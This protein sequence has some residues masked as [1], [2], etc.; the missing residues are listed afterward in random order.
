MSAYAAIV[1]RDARVAMRR[2]GE[3]AN[4]LLFFLIVTTLFPLALS[5][6][7]DELREVGVGV[8]WVSTLLSSL[9]ALE[10]LF[11]SDADDGSL[12]QLLL[13]PV[14][15][16]VTVLAKI[17]A[18]WLI[19]ILP[20]IALVPVLALSYSMPLSALPIMLA[21]LVLAT[22][23]LSVLIAIGAALTVSLRRG[24]TIVGLLV[25][26]LTAPL[27]IFGTR[28]TDFGLHDEPV[29]GP[30]YLLAAFAAF[31]LALGPLA[32]G[33]ALRVGVE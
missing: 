24:G 19:T 31:A 20:L 13:S 30:L 1:R 17:T 29:A 32:I 2:L 27:L 28:A 14:P 26:P 16:T 3:A 15:I 4:P 33:A 5:P 8:L 10:G 7:A 18:H 22:P 21:A 6:S 25:L 11:R 12:E 9:L 23:T